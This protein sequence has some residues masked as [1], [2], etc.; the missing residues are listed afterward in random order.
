M[1]RLSHILPLLFSTFFT[2]R[3]NYLS[4]YA[5]LQEVIYKQRFLEF[6][7][8]PENLKGGLIIDG[9]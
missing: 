3:L 8:K 6:G 7:I 1:T 9:F 4:H 2:L 5:I